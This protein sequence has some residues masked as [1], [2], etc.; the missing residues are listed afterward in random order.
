[1]RGPTRR[2]YRGLPREPQRRH[3]R[4]MQNLKEV[5]MEP[6]EDQGNWVCFFVHFL[7]TKET[8]NHRQRRAVF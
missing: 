6:H 4:G 1:M 3:S 5:F 2:A 7:S 8:W